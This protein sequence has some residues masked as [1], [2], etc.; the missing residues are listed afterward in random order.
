MTFTEAVGLAK[1]GNEAGFTYLYEQTYKKSFYVA[2]KYM[3]NDDTGAE[4]VLQIAYVKAF[5]NLGQL[6][7]P[8]KFQGWFSRIVANT[9][10]RELQKKTPTLFSQMNDEDT[11]IKFE[12]TIENSNVDFQPEASIDGKET[13]RLVKE[14]L[15]TLSDEQRMCVMMY[16]YEDIPVKDE[17]LILG[18]SENT[19]KSRLNYGRKAIKEKVLDLEKRGTKLYGILPIGFF[20]YLLKQDAAA[21]T[22][23][24]GL[25]GISGIIGSSAKEA[26]TG[27]HAGASNIAGKAASSAAKAAIHVKVTIGVVAAVCAVTGATVAVKNNSSKYTDNM[28]QDISEVIYD[29]QKEDQGGIESTSQAI[30]DTSQN[31]A[32]LGNNDEETVNTEETMSTEETTAASTAASDVSESDKK[33]AAEEEASV[34]MLHVYSTTGRKF[35]YD[36]EDNECFWDCI[37]CYTLLYPEQCKETERIASDYSLDPF[38]VDKAVVEQVAA[39]L[40]TGCKHLLPIPA[41]YQ[42]TDWTMISVYSDRYMMGGSDPFLYDCK[43]QSWEE[44]GDGTYTAKY[45]FYD[46][47]ME[48]CAIDEL[49]T[50]GTITYCDN[51]YSVGGAKPLL[52]I[53]VISAEFQDI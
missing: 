49:F 33:E 20:I 47:G 41:D 3:K 22:P 38:P 18:V 2:K 45:A 26:K 1:A 21:A 10:F 27:I 51:T 36:P 15:D 48:S 29:K 9:S 25:A 14:M 17:A 4:D 19:V 43:L 16:Y 8:E 30:L 13:Q 6:E 42:R 23:L 34:I 5:S 11:D 39:G 37:Y 24:A 31:I 40:F 53:S 46:E 28:T 50:I 44:N 35:N 7:D 12:D 32:R 52:P